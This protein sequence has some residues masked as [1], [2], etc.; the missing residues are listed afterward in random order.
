LFEEAIAVYRKAIGL[1]RDYS[2]AHNNLA[3]LLANCPDPRFRD[4]AEAVRLAKRAVELGRG[5]AWNTLGAA[6]Y[7][8][9]DWEAAVAALE[10]SVQLRGGGD[11]FD[12]FFLA[13]A[14]GRLGH[15]EEARKWYDKAAQW[16]EKNQPRDE[17][18]RR[19]DA[20]AAE[21]LGLK[22]K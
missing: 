5:D 4:P 7:R 16:M 9:G 14:H 15:Q 11:S 20:E 1:N 17:E 18:L 13:M 2:L 10:K 3:W 6:Y 8:T 19:F 22:K 12:W 21:L